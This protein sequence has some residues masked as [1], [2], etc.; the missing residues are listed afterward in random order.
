MATNPKLIKF[1]FNAWRQNI[2]DCAI[3]AVVAATGLDYREVCKRFGVSYKKG[4]GLI[5]DTGIGL[6]QIEETFSEYFDI[7]E[8]FYNNYDFVPDEMKGSKE[9]L[10]MQKFDILNG[11]TDGAT[12]TTLNEFI[13]MFKNQGSF[14]VSLIENPEAINS[15]SRKGGH[16]VCVNCRRGAK[17]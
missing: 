14:L 2:S 3:R 12:K 6:D 9:D 4:K 13:D 10:E 1:N 15:V 5:R 11:I 8:D 17:K 7:V 16:I